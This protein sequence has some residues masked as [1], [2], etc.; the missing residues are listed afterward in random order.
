MPR[1]GHHHERFPEQPF[2]M[3]GFTRRHRNVDG[4]IKGTAREFRFQIPALYARRGNR[5]LWSLA[6]QTL[7]QRREDQGS[8]VLPE[9]DVEIAAGMSGIELVTFAEIYL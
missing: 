5:H 1:A 4:E 7:Q 3:N 6:L 2:L 8:D 9:R